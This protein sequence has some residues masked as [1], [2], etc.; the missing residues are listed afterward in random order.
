MQF[1]TVILTSELQIVHLF[2]G[3]LLQNIVLM[4]V[5]KIMQN[6]AVNQRKL[7]SAAERCT[8]TTQTRFGCKSMI[9]I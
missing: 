4:S 7:Q 9:M 8:E 5:S 2:R 3:N 1:L 6:V